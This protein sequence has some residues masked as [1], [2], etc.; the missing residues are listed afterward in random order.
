MGKNSS[1]SGDR[2][3]LLHMIKR[4]PNVWVSSLKELMEFSFRPSNHL[5]ATSP[6]LDRKTLHI[7]ASSLEWTVILIKLA[8]VFY[9]VHSTIVNSERR[10]MESLRKFHPLYLM[11]EM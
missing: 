10:S 5:I 7:K 6:K 8:H 9:K 11:R 4:E 1:E 3:T 2:G